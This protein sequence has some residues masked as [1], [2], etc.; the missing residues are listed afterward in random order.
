MNANI[1]AM[2]SERVFKGEEFNVAHGERTSLNELKE[3]I[4]EATGRR[5]L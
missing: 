1:L 2:Q 3:M 5:F 4:E